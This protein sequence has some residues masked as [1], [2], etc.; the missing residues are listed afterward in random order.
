MA[1]TIGRTA[2]L[3]RATGAGNPVTTASL[4]IQAGET[5]AV[6]FIKTVGATDRAGGAPTWNGPQ[7]QTFV[8]AN[9]TQKAATTPEAGIEV[10]YLLNPVLGTGTI[11][12]PNTGAA[13]LFWE[14]ATAQAAAGGRSA[15]DVAGGANAT[16]TNPSPGAIVTTEDGAAVFAAVAG[17]HANMLNATPAFSEISE[18]D[19]GAHGY[20]SQYTMQATKGSITMS[21]THGTGDDWGAVA[22]AFKEVPPLRFQS[23]MGVESGSGMSVTEKIR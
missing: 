6:L 13:T 3:A 22:V 10:W 17:G 12:I 9:A 4:T 16:S 14:V 8:Q 15:F 21:W 23:Y 19:D 18:V 1:H 20:A 7:T 5:V 2:A 11:T